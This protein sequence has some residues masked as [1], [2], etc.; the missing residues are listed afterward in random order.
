MIMKLNTNM[1][2]NMKKIL[3]G[4][5]CALL[6][7]GTYAETPSASY[8][9]WIGPFTITKVARYWDGAFRLTIHVKEVPETPC[10]L[11]NTNK[12]FTT[13]HSVNDNFVVQMMGLAA[14]AEAQNKKIRLLT[15]SPCDNNYGLSFVGVELISE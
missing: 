13:H 4:V 10:S 11:N 1:A 12:T 7:F 14:T 6:S 2:K 8:Q 3:L 9:D 5:F 15:S